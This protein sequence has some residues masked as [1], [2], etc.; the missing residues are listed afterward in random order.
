MYYRSRKHSAVR[1]R[2]KD[3]LIALGWTE[4]ECR[5]K[6]NGKFDIRVE[7][8]TPHIDNCFFWFENCLKKI[9]TGEAHWA[10]ETYAH[11]LVHLAW[12][13]NADNPNN[14]HPL[15]TLD[16]FELA[17]RIMLCGIDFNYY[18]GRE[19]EIPEDYT[20]EDYSGHIKII[21]W[22]HPEQNSFEFVQG[23]HGGLN[24]GFGWDFVLL[25]NA[26][27]VGAIILESDE[28]DT[29][30]APCQ[31][32]LDV[33]QDH[34]DSDYQFPVYCHSLILSNGKQILSGD[35]WMELD[36]FKA[37][38]SLAEELKP[39]DYLEHHIHTIEE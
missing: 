8:N 32:A 38:T 33:A 24:D 12:R 31:K 2:M 7:Y 29:A 23:W 10:L 1:Q 35:P 16:A 13:C 36:E 3:E 20:P 22:E 34:L 14:H 39:L 5:H 19:D 18:D 6:A 17:R 27:P 9:N 26:I 21:D 4:H 37:I 15:D 11:Q 25:V 28:K 30:Q